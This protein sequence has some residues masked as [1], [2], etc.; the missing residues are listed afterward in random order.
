[1]K[2]NLVR[3]LA[4]T[5]AT[6][7]ALLGAASSASA[8][9]VGP[10]PARPLELGIDAGALIGLDSPNI[11]TISIP[12]QEV[13]V[14]F[15]VNNKLS[16]EPGIGLYSA[17]GGG[18]NSTFYRFEVGGLW[19]FETSQRG[20]YVRPFVGFVGEHASAEGLSHSTTQALMGAGV[21]WKLRLN[22]IVSA[23]FEGN[24]EHDFSSGDAG[25]S[26]GIGLRAGLSLFAR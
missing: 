9:A 24:Y 6:G 15:F 12:A 2:Q 11:T 8:Q 23:R 14:G 7:V 19:H 1:M 18:S 3:T 16:F 26:N 25:S 17:S 10:Q 4:C 21:G 22:N 13:R 5:F 20:L